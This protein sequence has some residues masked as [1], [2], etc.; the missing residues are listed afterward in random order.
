MENPGFSA[1]V[2]VFVVLTTVLAVG[3]LIAYL[4]AALSRFF[5]RNVPSQAA[6]SQA[7]ALAAAPRADAR[8]PIELG[9]NAEPF[10]L[11]TVGFIVAFILCLVFVTVPPHAAEGGENAKPA[12]EQKK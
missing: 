6:L 3:A 1:F 9:P 10:I 2:I 7:M 5:A 11:A 8:E 4:V 12:L